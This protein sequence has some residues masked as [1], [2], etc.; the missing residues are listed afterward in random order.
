MLRPTTKTMVMVKAFAYGSGGAEIA[1][2]LQYLKA[3]YLGVAYAD[4]G[5]ELRKAGIT[6]PIMVLNPEENAFDAITDNYLEPDIF[7]I[8]QFDAFERH[9]QRSGL[10][11]YP[12]HIEVETGMNRLGF[13]TTDIKMLGGKIKDNRFVKIRSVFSHLAASEDA[14]EDAFTWH[15]YNLLLQATETLQSIIGYDF[16]RHIANS[17]AIARFPKLQLDLVRLGI[18][19]YGIAGKKMEKKLVPALT[20][21]STIAQIKHIK[22]GETIS[23]N[24]RG[25]AKKNSVIATIRI[26]YADGYSRRFG[27]GVGGVI[28]K[29]KRASVIGTV[30]MDMMM[31]DVTHIKNIKEGDEVII[32]GHKLPLQ[33]VA[34]SIGTIPYEIMTGI[35]QRVKRVYWGEQN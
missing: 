18:G 5:V 25:I 15:Q 30:C 22:K 23:Y 13:A 12:I 4:E 34:E 28:I 19:L 26:G 20:L 33:K 10:E 6:I 29:N 21:K 31:V 1:G 7:S 32:F 3:D 16:L 17:S 24:R 11:N 35:S 2:L 8:E 9:L 14:V 27:N